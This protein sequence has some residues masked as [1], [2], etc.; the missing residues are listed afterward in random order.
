[1]I[2]SEDSLFTLTHMQI[3]GVLVL[4]LLMWA[5]LV[6]ALYRVRHANRAYRI[7]LALGLFAGFVWLSPQVYYLFYWATFD[8]LPLQSVVRSPPSPLHLLRLLTFTE[9]HSLS[10]H[11]QGVLGW[12][13]LLVSWRSPASGD[14][15]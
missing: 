7:G 10:R 15:P 14:R 12:S 9:E 11:G 1:M 4:S 6:A 8:G 5:A 2:Y 13:L 3:A